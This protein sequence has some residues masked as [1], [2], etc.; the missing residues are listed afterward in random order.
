MDICRDKV[1]WGSEIRWGG[2][3]AAVDREEETGVESEQN[4]TNRRGLMRRQ[5]NNALVRKAGDQVHLYQ[6]SVGSCLQFSLL[7][8]LKRLTP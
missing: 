8:P 1:G 2:D 5:N 3:K 4:C 7:R 6:K